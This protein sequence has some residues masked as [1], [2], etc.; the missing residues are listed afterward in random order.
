[1]I[2]NKGYVFGVL[3]MLIS[4][5]GIGQECNIIYVSPSGSGSGTQAAPTSFLNAL[6]LVSPGVDHIRMAQGTY[7][8]SSTIDLI[9]GV[10]IEGGFNQTT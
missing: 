3:F 4:V 9:G 10:T 6:T 7:N 2:L 8:I 5:F 1:M